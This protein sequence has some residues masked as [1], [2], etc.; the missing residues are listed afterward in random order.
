MH[1]YTQHYIDGT[2]CDPSIPSPAIDVFDASTEQK[3]GSVPV[4]SADDVARAVRAAQRALVEWSASTPLFRRELIGKIHD[5]L[6]AQ[7]E[8][9]AQT[10]AS[11]VGTPIT[12]SRAIQLG[13]AINGLKGFMDLLE[14]YSFTH[15]L[16]TVQVLK[17]PIG[18]VAAITPWNYPLHQIVCKL[19]AALAAGC[20]V[21]LKPSEIAPLNAFQLATIIHNSGLPNGVFNLVSGTGPTVGEALCSQPGVDMISFTGSTRAGKRVATLAAEGLKKVSLELGGKGPFIVLEDADFSKA[22]PRGV[23]QCF[24]NSGQTCSALTRMLVPRAKQAEAVALAVEHAQKQRVGVASDESMQLGPL[25][26]H[27]QWQRVQHFIQQGIDSGAKLATGGLGKP[28]GLQT[29]HFCKPT[30]FFDVSND[31]AIAR[32]EIFGPVLCIIPY[33]SVEQAVELANDSPYGLGGGV[34]GGDIETAKSLAKRLRLGTVYVNNG[35][36][37]IGA[38]FGGVKHS[39]YGREAGVYGLEEFLVAKALYL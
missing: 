27:T 14:S 1:T 36:Y 20:T 29:G 17:E 16:G 3:I 38:P 9:I 12:R 34:W 24:L 35:K 5:G 25:I 10:I 7:K 37:S 4:S 23:D 30:V 13:L 33:D 18:V 22:I 26:T 2:F 19:G 21:V 31:S 39:G 11:E 32:E 8:Q 28:E 6:V 15:P